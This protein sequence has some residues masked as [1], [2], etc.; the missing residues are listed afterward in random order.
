ML[1]GVILHCFSKIY[2]PWR[3]GSTIMILTHSNEEM[4]GR[5]DG[6]DSQK[7]MIIEHD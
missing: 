5:A 1:E 4:E 6:A 3:R 2:I 7:I